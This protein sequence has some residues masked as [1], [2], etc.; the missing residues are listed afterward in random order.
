VTTPRSVEFDKNILLIVDNNVLVVVGDN[1]SNRSI[2]L[3]WDGLRLD[4]RLDLTGQ[5]VV[6]KLANM[7]FSELSALLEGE[8]LVLGCVLDSEGGPFAD[9]EVQVLCMLAKS[10]CVDRCNVNLSLVLCSD[11]LECLCQF[12]TLLGS[13][14]ENVGEG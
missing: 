8:F 1:S 11:R 13:F 3:F 14:S 10:L 5:E 6:N 4:A 12:F 9:F 7:L 2:V